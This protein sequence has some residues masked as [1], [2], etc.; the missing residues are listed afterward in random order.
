MN[1]KMFLTWSCFGKIA[2]V[3]VESIAVHLGNAEQASPEESISGREF[4]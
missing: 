3:N 2:S 4:Q 1:T